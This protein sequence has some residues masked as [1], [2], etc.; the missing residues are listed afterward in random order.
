MKI[1]HDIY[2]GHSTSIEKPPKV[3]GN[4]RGVSNN[5]RTQNMKVLII[6]E[7]SIHI[8]LVQDPLTLVKADVN[9]NV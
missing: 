7:R 4:V 6:Y 2:L 8:N 9:V 1:C 5:E 3:N